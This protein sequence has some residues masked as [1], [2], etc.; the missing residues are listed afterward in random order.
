[1]TAARP[2]AAPE[3]CG[4]VLAAGEGQRLRPLTA[5]VP[6]ALCPVGNLPLLDHALRRLAGLGLSGPGQVGVN[7]AYL[8]D[9]VVAHA[10]GRAHLS[11]ELDGPLGTSGG[12]ARLK[13]WID[14]RGVLVGNADAYL[15]DPF[16]E[17]GKDIA[18]LLSGWSGDTVRMLTKPCRPGETGGFSGH[19]FA[20]FS[21]IPWRFVA[22]LADRNTDLV[23]TVWR[24]AEAEQA[25]ELIGY[26][27]FYLDTG[28]PALYLEANLHAAGAG[29]VDPAAEVTG[30][31]MESVIGAG[32]RVAGSVTRCVVW[33][34]ATVEPGE[35]LS[36]VIRAPGGL[37]VPAA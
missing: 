34:G 35:S 30:A 21:L 11:V 23:R 5:S 4:V 32:A 29:L 1:M 22:G 19:R 12:V 20:G 33:P 16:R 37:T 28:T 25:L 14:G 2:G 10:T 3:I 36:D 6:K 18:A 24:P 9:Q 17:P 8:A 26:E 7:A 31:A 15:A 27:G 13:S